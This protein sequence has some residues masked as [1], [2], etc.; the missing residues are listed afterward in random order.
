MDPIQLAYCRVSLRYMQMAADQIQVQGIMKKY[1]EEDEEEEEDNSGDDDDELLDKNPEELAQ[2]E[3]DATR[4]LQRFKH[5][6]Q[7]AWA[8]G[9]GAEGDK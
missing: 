2:L 6:C 8:A 1:R 7:K 9:C 3:R 4:L 5:N